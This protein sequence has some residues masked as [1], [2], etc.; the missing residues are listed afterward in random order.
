M[1]RQR[2]IKGDREKENYSPSV[3]VTDLFNWIENSWQQFLKG[4]L[5]STAK[6]DIT[7]S[8]LR[9]P[10]HE[11]KTATQRQEPWIFIRDNTS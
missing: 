5:F 9:F 3:V 4:K 1:Y 7:S 11:C 2:E 10:G 8:H 6:S